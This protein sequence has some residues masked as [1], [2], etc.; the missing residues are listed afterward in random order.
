QDLGG[1]APRKP[2]QANAA[3]PA[4][5]RPALHRHLQSARAPRLLRADA[6]SRPGSLLSLVYQFPPG[7][8]RHRPVRRRLRSVSGDLL[9]QRRR[10]VDR[11]RLAPHRVL[12]RRG[13]PRPEVRADPRDGLRRL[14]DRRRAPRGPAPG[15]L[16]LSHA[17]R[18]RVPGF[19]ALIHEMVFGVSPTDGERLVAQRREAWDSPTYRVARS[20]MVSLYE[21]L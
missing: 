18:R 11:V 19:P 16:G 17:I 20:Q 21:H 3:R 10:M 7:L 2:A 8:P 15:S 6:A 9:P 4:Q 14:P 5:L 13:L 1:G 12:P